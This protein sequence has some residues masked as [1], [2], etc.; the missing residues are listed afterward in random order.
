MGGI[1]SGADKLSRVAYLRHDPATAEVL[2][3]EAVPSESTW[4]HLFGE[5]AAA[6]SQRMTAWHAWA[7]RR[8]PS[9]RPGCTLDLDSRSLLPQVG[10]QE[11]VASGYTKER[12]RPRHHPPAEAPCEAHFWLRCGD[13]GQL[14]NAQELLRSTLAGLPAQVR[15]GLLRCDGGFYSRRRLDTAREKGLRYIVGVPLTPH[16]QRSCRHDDSR[17]SDSEVKGLQVPELEGER[18]GERLIVIR[19]R[20]A[21]RREAGGKILFDLTDYLFQAFVTNLLRTQAMRWVYGGATMAGWTWRNV[22]RNSGTGSASGAFAASRTGPPR[23]C[24]SWRS[25]PRI[26]ACCSSGASAELRSLSR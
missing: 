4:S 19:H 6:S 8:L 13:A 15:I 24:A 26:S 3:I 20:I 7:L 25:P 23:R 5:S 10:E 21:Q 12:L 22:S 1:L 18:P 2:G 14:N 9:L 16:V 11:C 17:W